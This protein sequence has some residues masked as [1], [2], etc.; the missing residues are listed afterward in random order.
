MAVENGHA[1]KGDALLGMTGDLTDGP[2]DFQVGVRCDQQPLAGLFINNR[3]AFQPV[4]LALRRDFGINGP[5]LRPAQKRFQVP[6]QLTGG[7]I[8]LVVSGQP[9]KDG[10]LFCLR[11]SPNQ[12]QIGRPQVPGLE[13][14]D[15]PQV[16][17]GVGIPLLHRLRRCPGGV[18]LVVVLRHPLPVA[19][20][21]LNHLPPQIALP[22]QPLQGRFRSVAQLPEGVQQRLVGRS[23]G[24]QVR[25]HPARRAGGAPQRGAFHDPI[26]RLPVLG[27]QRRRA[28]KLG[29]AG[30]HQEPH[31]GKPGA[32]HFPPQ[33]Q[34]GVGGRPNHRHRRQGFAPLQF[35][36]EPP[37]GQ[38]ALGREAVEVQPG[39]QGHD[40]APGVCGRPASLPP[41]RP[42]SGWF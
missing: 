6:G 23:M 37:Q 18:G 15:E 22:R 1:V 12:R 28:E 17:Q 30:Q 19:L 16:I 3:R 5:R 31:V 38:V 32:S 13:E 39:A 42:I 29:Q 2:P 25:Q 21:K 33:S 24:T 8:G 27:H 4:P 35:R 36:N 14:N 41:S 9:Q 34:V 7:G 11:Q 10:A 40:M 26:Q 20:V